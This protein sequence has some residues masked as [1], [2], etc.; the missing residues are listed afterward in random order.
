[1]K[2]VAIGAHPDDIEFGAG[3]TLAKHLSMG[4]DVHGVVCTLGGVSGDAAERKEESY[5]AASILGMNAITI[6]DYSA[7]AL[8][9]PTPTFAGEIEK[10]LSEIKPDRVYTHTSF[11]YHQVHYSVNRAVAQ[12][13]RKL[14]VRDVLFFEI[15]SSTSPEFRPNAFVDVT[16]F[17]DKK[18][19][20][21]QAHKS[22]ATTRFYLQPNVIRSLANTRYVWGKVGPDS[23][24]L[25]EAFIVR[26][27]GPDAVIKSTLA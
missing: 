1:M 11:D 10:I 16:D 17:I 22:Q 18:I 24:G 14:Q 12:A 6:M 13:S 21:L 7:A 25:A 9:K 27:L 3:G 26:R 5:Q 15:L 19:K 8:N 2:V 4:D 23:S 20:S